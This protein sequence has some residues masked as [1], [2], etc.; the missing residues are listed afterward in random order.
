MS[1]GM[2]PMEY[3]DPDTGYVFV[4]SGRSMI[5]VGMPWTNRLH[6]DVPA[7]VDMPYQFFANISVRDPETDKP[8]IPPEYEAFKTKCLEWVEDRRGEL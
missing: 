2:A 6:G 1:E 8:T 5:D 3:I 4:W 7:D